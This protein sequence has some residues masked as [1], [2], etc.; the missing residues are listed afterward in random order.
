MT[1]AKG[2]KTQKLLYFYISRTN[3]SYLILY[4]F[5]INLILN[6]CHNIFIKN[7]CL[8]KHLQQLLEGKIYKFFKLIFDTLRR[9]ELRSI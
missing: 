4:V 7:F 9:F 6:Q 8:L 3:Y 2:K 1:D 5:I